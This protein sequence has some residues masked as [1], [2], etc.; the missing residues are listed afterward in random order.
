MVQYKML[1]RHRQGRKTDWIYRPDR[2]FEKEMDRMKRFS[3]FAFSWST[4]IPDKPTSFLP[5]IRKT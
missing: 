5:Q 4:G 1:E 3:Q 2:Q